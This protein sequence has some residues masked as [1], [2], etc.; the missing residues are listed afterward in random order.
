MVPGVPITNYNGYIP[1]W[2]CKRNRNYV[3]VI[4]NKAAIPSG[5]SLEVERWK[6]EEAPNLVLNLKLISP[7]PL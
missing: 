3:P 1:V 5:R 2:G 4:D 6:I 7:V